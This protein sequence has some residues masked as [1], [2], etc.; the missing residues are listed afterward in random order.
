MIISG[1]VNVYPQEIE[2]T[3]ITHERVADVAVFGIPN[4]EF[5]EEVKAVVQP[6][7]WSDAGDELAQ[8]LMQLCKRR[9]SGVKCPRSIDFKRELPRLD[10][11][12]L[13]KRLLRDS[14]LRTD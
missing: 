12:K 13:Y 14:Y 6:R 7:H 3:L 5:G 11:G 1:G 2:N 4:A 9:L 10:N 8:E